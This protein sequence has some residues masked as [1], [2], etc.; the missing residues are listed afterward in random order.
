MT[1]IIL[2]SWH[3]LTEMAPYLLLGF[4]VAGILSIFLSPEYVERH[5]GGRGVVPVCKAALF[6]VP[7]PLCSCGVVPVATS[8][9]QHGASSG[10]TTSFLLSTPQTGVDSVLVTYSL[11]GWVF[12]VVRPIVAFL[13]GLVGGSIVVAIDS[14][15][16]AADDEREECQDACCMDDDRS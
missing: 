12:A 2:E 13:T 15:N 9:R 16:S 5:L 4:L 14:N 1:E 10:A 6:G 8:L 11:L 3:L 7:L